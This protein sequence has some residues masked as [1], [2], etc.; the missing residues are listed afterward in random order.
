MNVTYGQGA[1]LQDRMKIPGTIILS[2]HK[3]YIKQDGE[4]LPQTFVPLEKIERIQLSG[5]VLSIDV[6]PAIMSRYRAAFEAEKRNI[7]EL[8][9]EIVKRR[10]LKKRFLRNE[11][12]EVPA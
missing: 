12:V 9:H 5:H 1:F 8:T 2:D 4:D 7:T 11:W 3:I 6:R 10:G